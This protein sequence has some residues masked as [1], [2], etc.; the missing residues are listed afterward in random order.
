MEVEGLH[1]Y[2]LVKQS[3]MF[4]RLRINHA[5]AAKLTYL[6]GKVYCADVSIM[7]RRIT[8]M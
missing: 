7:G 3:A 5:C 4:G 6:I 8:G 2:D 1:S